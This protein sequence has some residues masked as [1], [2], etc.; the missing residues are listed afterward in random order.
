MLVKLIIFSF[1]GI[2]NLIILFLQDFKSNQLNYLI[3]Y[4]FRLNQSTDSLQI[5]HLFYVEVYVLKEKNCDTK[6]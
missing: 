2:P 5:N 1:V 6:K 3:Y 4:I